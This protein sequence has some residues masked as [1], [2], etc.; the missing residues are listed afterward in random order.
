MDPANTQGI[1]TH[2]QEQGGKAN[3]PWQPHMFSSFPSA[4]PVPQGWHCGWAGKREKVALGP[5]K[6]C[7]WGQNPAAASPGLWL[8]L[9]PGHLGLFSSCRHLWALA[10]ISKHLL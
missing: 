6:I 2:A 1:F 10:V 5:P 7:V 8:E 4:A 9:P 3:S